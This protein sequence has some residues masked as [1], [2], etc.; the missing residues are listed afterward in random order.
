M[1]MTVKQALSI[2]NGITHVMNSQSG[3]HSAV[4]TL[5]EE[6]ERLQKQINN[7]DI[8]REEE[9]S[10]VLIPCDNPEFGG[11][12]ACYVEVAAEWTVWQSLRFPGESLAEAL[13]NAVEAKS[14]AG[15]EID[16]PS[17]RPLG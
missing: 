12:P 5:A 13:E 10:S 6:V 16:D 2:A 17:R 14:Q 9:G 15:G 4:V 1:T 7:L 3:V 8:L 11:D